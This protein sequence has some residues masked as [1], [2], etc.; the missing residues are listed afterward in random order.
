MVTEVSLL[1]GKTL[2]QAIADGTVDRPELLEFNDFQVWRRT[3]GRRPTQR[4]DGVKRTTAQEAELW[5]K[6]M[7]SLYGLDWAQ[8]L[9]DKRVAKAA[10]EAPDEESEV[11]VPKSPSQRAAAAEPARPVVEVTPQKSE[12]GRSSIPDNPEQLKAR[13]G[14][15]YDPGRETS[16][17][18]L[19]RMQRLV[20][21]MGALGEL[22]FDP[23]YFIEV[24]TYKSTLAE[25]AFKRNW[26]LARRTKEW[27]REYAVEMATEEDEAY[28]RDGGARL[29]ALGELLEIQCKV[30]VEALYDRIAKGLGHESPPSRATGSRGRKLGNFNICTPPVSELQ[31]EAYVT[32]KQLSDTLKKLQE[33]EVMKAAA[34]LQEVQ[35]AGLD[36]P[37]LLRLLERQTEILERGKGDSGGSTIRIQP[38][39]QWPTLGDG[40]AGNKEVEEF[41]EKIE[42]IFD[43]ARDGKGMLDRER[44]VTLKSC[45]S[46]SR[47]KIYDNILKKR[48]LESADWESKSGEIYIEIKKRLMKFC[49]TDTEKQLWAKKQFDALYKHKHT[50]AAQ[51]EASWEEALADLEEVGLGRS[52]LEKYLA[53]VE[54]IGA[55]LSEKVRTDRRPR[56]DKDG[57]MVTRPPKTW[58]EAHAV[59]VEHETIHAGTKALGDHR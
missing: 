11:E 52:E 8:Q 59:V 9:A 37:S 55:S 46:G 30:D 32:P 16:Q 48:K 25:E 20:R 38:R 3:S 51:F 33:E 47:R 5:R 21:A 22:D 35:T 19:A 45:L 10:E 43:L 15:E 41:F 7:E 1:A 39:M 12:S 28:F 23:E 14:K 34:K 44:L 53:Y 6:T 40:G 2:E 56:P 50:S 31:D 27:K 13:M 42:E 49:L 36:T 17:E 58:E 29:E 54:K 26:D 4:V 18:Y 24:A 57:S